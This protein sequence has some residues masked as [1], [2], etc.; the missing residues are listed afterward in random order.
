MCF[1]FSILLFALLTREMI[2]TLRHK[3]LRKQLVNELIG[4]GIKNQKV[5]HAVNAIPRHIFMDQAFVRFAYQ[6]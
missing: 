1:S 6:V 4:K 2:D 5:L 3:G